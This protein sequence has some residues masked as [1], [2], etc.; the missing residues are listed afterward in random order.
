MIFK[1]LNR[2]IRLY[3]TIKFLKVKQIKY[4]IYYLLRAKIRKVMGFNLVLSKKSK[5]VSL[6]LKESIHIID[7]YKGSDKGS[8]EFIFLNLTKKFDN[9]D[10]IDW[11][12]S[13]YGKLW[14]YN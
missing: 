8:N 6:N 12:Y 11:N 9:F 7:T 3:N 5:S 4:R 14:T 10:K 1:Q 2:Y 13:A